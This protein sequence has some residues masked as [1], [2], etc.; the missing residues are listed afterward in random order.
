VRCCGVASGG[1]QGG[2]ECSLG[3]A[4]PS[5]FMPFAR[6]LSSKLWW[7]VAQACLPGGQGHVQPQE[8]ENH[9]SAAVCRHGEDNRLESNTC[10]E[11]CYVKPVTRS[12]SACCC[13]SLRRGT[14]SSPAPPPPLNRRHLP[15]L[16]SL[17]L[18]YTVESSMYVRTR[19]R[20]AND[21]PMG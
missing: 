4:Y 18:S 20:G 19:R 2:G 9:E 21:A 11:A 14:V 12:V 10:T 16:S 17:S 13:C 15:S 7:R 3:A 5:R 6:I 8:L 1:E